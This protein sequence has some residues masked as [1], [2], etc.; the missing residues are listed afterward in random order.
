MLTQDDLK[1]YLNYDPLTGIF[2][3]VRSA[4]GKKAGTVAGYT[5]PLGYIIIQVKGVSYRAHRLAFL[6]MEG[7]FPPDQVDH[8]DRNPSNNAWSNLRK[9]TSAENQ[10][11][12]SNNISKRSGFNYI[13]GRTS[14]HRWYVI[15]K[16]DSSRGSFD[17]V[18]EAIPILE[19]ILL[20]AN[21]TVGLER[22]YR[23]LEAYKTKQA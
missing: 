13:R 9:C 7:A 15:Y 21:D 23:Q 14:T 3:R 18:E 10:L 4:G 11:N 1:Y 2:T 16:T 6:Y 8:I 20:E 22:F 12:K 17:T 19:K 5:D